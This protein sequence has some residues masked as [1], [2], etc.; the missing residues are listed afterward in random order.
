MSS[1]FAGVIGLA[2][3]FAFN[4]TLL[5]V[6]PKPFW[7]KPHEAAVA[8]LLAPVLYGIGLLIQFVV[9]LL[10]A[11]GVITLH[12]SQVPAPGFAAVASGVVAVC[13]AHVVWARRKLQ[14]G[15]ASRPGG[16]GSP[17]LVITGP[18]AISRSPG[19]L[20]AVTAE[21]CQVAL[22]GSIAA[23]V[24]LALCWL[25][26]EVAVHAVTEPELEKRFGPAW[27]EWAKGTGRFVPIVG[28]REVKETEEAEVEEYESKLEDAAAARHHHDGPPPIAPA[29][30]LD[31]LIPPPND[32]PGV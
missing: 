20:A 2:L 10:T 1:Q 23:L 9:D 28:T 30:G 8:A 5:G 17:E 15:R 14:R 32:S 3:L 13:C 21:I 29:A 22:V 11:V 18:F 26:V 4:A 25:A 27:I 24:A 19:G 31:S 7:E 16:R 6:P 12:G